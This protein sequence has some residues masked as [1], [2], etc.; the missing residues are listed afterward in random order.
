MRPGMIT[1]GGTD[2]VARGS[3]PTLLLRSWE[4]H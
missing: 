4:F 1:A 2:V 3:R